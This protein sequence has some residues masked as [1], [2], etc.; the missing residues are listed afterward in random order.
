MTLPTPFPPQ[1][2]AFPP[3]SNP[4]STPPS[5]PLPTPLPGLCFQ[6]PR[7]PGL[8]R[9]SPCAF[10]RPA[11]PCTQRRCGPSTASSDRRPSI[12]QTIPVANR[13]TAHSWR[14]GPVAAGRTGSRP[15]SPAGARPLGN[16]RGAGGLRYFPAPK[17]CGGARPGI[18]LVAGGK[19]RSAPG[20]PAVQP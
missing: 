17:R 13:A 6:P 9:G 1:K 11:T 7:T 16:G 19:S 2:I 5:N 15:S 3:P 10:G 14:V 18:S 8:Q 12:R 4:R 20:N